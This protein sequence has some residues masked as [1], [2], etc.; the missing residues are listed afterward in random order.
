MTCRAEGAITARC[1]RTSPSLRTVSPGWRSW[2]TRANV[3]RAASMA[4]GG[5]GAGHRT[6]PNP[7]NAF[8]ARH[9]AAG[10]VPTSARPVNPFGVR[11][12]AA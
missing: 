11:G 4:D 10:S 5:I 7:T 3:A 8:N 6:H 9:I 2:V 12:F 1:E